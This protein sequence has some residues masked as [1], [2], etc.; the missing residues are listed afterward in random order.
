MSVP[1]RR[2][3]LTPTT[4]RSRRPRLRVVAVQATFLAVALACGGPAAAQSIAEHT[5]GMERLDGFV[6]LHWDEDA[7]RLYMEIGRFDQDFLYLRSLAT[8]I[9]S[10]ALG[11]DRGEIF[12]EFV[13]RFERAGGSVHFVLTNPS[14]RAATAPTAALER[15]VEESF[16]TS[17]L[18]SWKVVASDGGRALVDATD[19]FL[20]DGVDLVGRL[21]RAGQGTFRVD[22]G[23]SRIHRPRTRAFPENTEV[24]AALT[25][26]SAAPGPE[27]RAHTPDGRALTLRQ[28]H[29]F[30]QLPDDG[31]TPR[32]FD[33]R[34][35][36]F[37]VSFFDYG[38]SFDQEYVT[39]YA[40]RHRLQ[41]R[42]PG[43][44]RS[45]PVEPIV[46][47]LD[48]AVPEP[49][50]TAF[51]EGGAW[52]NEI[53]EA[54][55]WIDA[56]RIED[57]PEDM[58]PMDAR[59]HVIQWVHRTEAGSS[60]GPSFRDPR[61]GEIIKAA[62]R[63]DSHRSLADY[64]LY[65]GALP[66]TG[67]REM[68]GGPGDPWG[69]AGPEV[70]LGAGGGLDWMTRLA[71]DV[72]A[73]EFA[74]ARRRQHSA[75]EIGHTLG[76]AHNFIA[77]SY[78]RASVM[79]YPAP[80]IEVESGQVRMADAYREGGGAYDTLAIRWAYTE[81]P[82]GQEVAGLEA[83]V[84]DG[85]ERGLKFITN[86]D[87]SASSSFP[88]A[89]TWI[90]GTDVLDEFERVMDVRRVLIDR[91]DEEAIEPGE[92]MW[93]LGERFVP[94]YLHHR[95]QLGAVI[96]TVGG[97]EF[98]YGVRGDPL[99]VTR[100]LDGARQRRALDL[101]VAS[102]SDDALDVPT[103]TLQ[104]LAPRPF[105]HAPIRVDFDSEAGP[106]FDHL[107]IARTLAA[108]A[109]GGVL[110]PERMARVAAFH[111]RDAS[112]PSTTE[113]VD[114][115]TSGLWDGGYG[116]PLRR[117][118]QR[119][120]VDELIDL[121]ADAEATVEARAA[122]EWGLRQIGARAATDAETAQ[123]P[124]LAHLQLAASDARR[125]LERLYEGGERTDALAPPPGTPIGN[126]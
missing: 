59:Y 117:V 12:D 118:V 36:V 38:K 108:T 86:S 30:V 13:A 31:Y 41:K 63:M 105:G 44:A 49:Y 75:H 113:V 89:T 4:R 53:F 3:A 60:I 109:L 80:L 29:S 48:R 50:R 72:T 112:L 52:W 39:R 27:I 124:V 67:S 24:E 40:V 103:A 21:Q 10:N 33:P 104:M 23:R 99:P 64:N 91:F 111:E 25:F 74:M 28:H 58:D 46:Y 90:N 123:G 93:R 17:T 84:Q 55:G 9:G 8:G 16:P 121:A 101:L 18:A 5:A 35:G 96:K 120:L 32:S 15:S 78:G 66:A 62:V 126:R 68:G 65:A 82:E 6:P 92:A 34:I 69:A 97:M 115:L 71:P 26:T 76:L 77:A 88:D 102:L 42:D 81:F 95:F 70:F 98:R 119:A 73:E 14:F 54:A 114:R 22:A 87:E 106:A 1:S 125:F 122:A 47:Y 11:L 20:E 116:T 19:F 57:M 45:A 37:A 85:M 83:I 43:A 2:S 94:V 51:K 56:F 107:G 7:G 110:H 61:T 79:D 100:V